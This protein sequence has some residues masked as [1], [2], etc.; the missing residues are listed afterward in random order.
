MALA[1]DRHYCAPDTCRCNAFRYQHRI[2]QRH[3]DRRDL[4]G[5]KDRLCT[6]KGTLLAWVSES[7][8][9]GVWRI[10]LPFDAIPNVFKPR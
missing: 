4:L 6:R 3:Q 9:F 2:I 1:H 7:R 5:S 10:G 8:G